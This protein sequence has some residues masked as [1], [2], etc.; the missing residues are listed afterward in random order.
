MANKRLFFGMTIVY[1]LL[2]FVLTKGLGSAFDIVET[3]REVEESIGSDGQ[4]LQTSYALF[5]YLLGSFNG[6]LGEA[7][8]TYQLFLSIIVILA[9]IWVCRQLFSGEKPGVRD[10]FY[11][12]MYPLIPFII[13]LVIMTIQLIPA[14]LG[15]FFLSTVL[16]QGLAVTLAEKFI[17]FLIFVSLSI[18]SLYMIISSIFA[19]NIVTLPD[20]R[21]LKA[22]RSARELVLHRRIG[23][24][25][26]IL[27]L[28]IAGFLITIVI[29][30]PLIMFA[31][32][33]V[34]PLFLVASCFGLIFITIYMYNFYRLLL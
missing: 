31:P 28:A 24:F 21:P 8:G 11:K 10:A 17:W 2:I 14:F 33:L 25:A 19:L 20:V 34:E 16:T 6:Q 32:V 29:F 1:S 13:V 18:L 22:L 15:N 30:V 27:F 9:T 3:K 12:G 4:K 5:N 7:A 23:I 26:R